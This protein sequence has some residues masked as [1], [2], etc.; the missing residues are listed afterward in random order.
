[1]TL[2]D[3]FYLRCRVSCWEILESVQDPCNGLNAHGTSDLMPYVTRADG[4]LAE[5]I[6]RAL[7]RR[8]WRVTD[9]LKRKLV[10]G[11]IE[12][13]ISAVRACSALRKEAN[14]LMPEM[15]ECLDAGHPDLEAWTTWTLAAWTPN[16]L[17]ILF[18]LALDPGTDPRARLMAAEGIEKSFSTYVLPG[19]LSFYGGKRVADSARAAKS[20]E[21]VLEEGL[22]ALVALMGASDEHVRELAYFAAFAS[23][24]RITPMRSPMTAFTCSRRRCA[25][26]A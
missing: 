16:S 8:S 24:E 13:R 9:A 25:R 23:S 3:P 22:P 20:R 10:K 21:I 11:D 14:V 2:P 6:G 5:W 12:E 17:P 19:G 7:A 15:R 4:L 18:D 1:M 26:A